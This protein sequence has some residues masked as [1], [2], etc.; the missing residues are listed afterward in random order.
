MNIGLVEIN[1]SIVAL[2]SLSSV[3]SGLKLL[4]SRRLKSNPGREFLDNLEW[5]L[6]IARNNGLKKLYILIESEVL[7][8]SY[9]G[10]SLLD[11]KYQGLSIK[12]LDNEFLSHI[13][14]PKLKSDTVNVWFEYEKIVI[15]YYNNKRPYV[16][17]FNEYESNSKIDIYQR[18]SLYDFPSAD[19]I[20]VSIHPL[21][22]D[23]NKVLTFTHAFLEYF[24]EASLDYERT[25]LIKIYGNK[26]LPGK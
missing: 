20:K 2:Y 7:M 5:L 23:M 10:F 3:S 22:E 19:F 18:L 8:S 6:L 26:M 1:R 25:P 15:G 24:A 13:I 11:K 12:Y 14:K 9:Q 17:V 21:L 4:D 16:Y